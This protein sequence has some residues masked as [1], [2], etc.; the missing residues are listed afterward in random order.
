[1]LAMQA[2]E[3]TVVQTIVRPTVHDGNGGLARPA[4]AVG[5]VGAR[6]GIARWDHEETT[7]SRAEQC[8][9]VR[10][11]KILERP[12]DGKPLAILPDEK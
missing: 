10:A 12:D 1:M 7:G 4:E 11:L 5:T 6:V 9:N 8:E 2:P 3:P